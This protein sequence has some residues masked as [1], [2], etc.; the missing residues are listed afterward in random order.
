MGEPSRRGASVKDRTRFVD[1]SCAS[2]HQT[3][4][5]AQPWS[6]IPSV[7]ATLSVYILQAS[8]PCFLPQTALLKAQFCATSLGRLWPLITQSFRSP[9]VV[10]CSA[11]L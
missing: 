4:D 2:W 7:P 6:F 9:R 8:V 1:P 11:R 3:L 10:P 5:Q